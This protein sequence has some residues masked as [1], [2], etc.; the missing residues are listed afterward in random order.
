MDTWNL[1]Q[2]IITSGMA[3]A[4]K[5]VGLDPDWLA[6]DPM[7]FYISRSDGIRNFHRERH[8]PSKRAEIEY[9]AK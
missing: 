6:S 1:N 8:F 5:V 7:I 2:G 3:T 9:D 4:V